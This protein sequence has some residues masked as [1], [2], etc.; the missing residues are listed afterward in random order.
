TALVRCLAS[1]TCS[2][3]DSSAQKSICDVSCPDSPAKSTR[4]AVIT[5]GGTSSGVAIVQSGS[6]GYIS[7]FW[8]NAFTIIHQRNRCSLLTRFSQIWKRNYCNS[9]D[10]YREH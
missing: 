8:R 10:C 4:A 5:F 7:M 6:S 1:T 9:T 2:S 3:D